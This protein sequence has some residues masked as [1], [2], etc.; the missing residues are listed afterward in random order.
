MPC[1]LN[2]QSTPLRL[3]LTQIRLQQW[4]YP[5]RHERR[6]PLRAHM[7]EYSQTYLDRRRP[8]PLCARGRQIHTEGRHLKDRQA[9][10]DEA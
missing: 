6:A 3:L 9:L 1:L 5:L 7:R 4:M 8:T 10:R 2:H